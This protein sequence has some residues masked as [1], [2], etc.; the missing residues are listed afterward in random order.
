MSWN[1]ASPYLL[2]RLSIDPHPPRALLTQPL[3]LRLIQTI[4]NLPAIAA[5]NVVG[6]PSDLPIRLETHDRLGYGF[7]RLPKE[8]SVFEGPDDGCSHGCIG[9]AGTDGI[10]TDTVALVEEFAGGAEQALDGVFACL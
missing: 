5:L 2:H 10:E 6:L 7:G 4:L 8:S 1:Q 9:Y 3:R